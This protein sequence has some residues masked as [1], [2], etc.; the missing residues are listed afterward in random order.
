MS[1]NQQIQFVSTTPDDL[2]ELISQKLKEQTKEKSINS[3][4]KQSEYLTIDE[5]AKLLKVTKS[6]LWRYEKRGK[7]IPYDFENKVYYKRS[8]IEKGFIKRS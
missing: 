6:T 1:K 8:E 7:L 5:T 4:Q 3:E 2:A